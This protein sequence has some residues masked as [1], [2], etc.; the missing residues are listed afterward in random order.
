MHSN[1]DNF[2]KENFDSLINTEKMLESLVQRMMKCEPEDF[3]L[4][5]LVSFV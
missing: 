4:V 1:D 3:E 5:S 2:D